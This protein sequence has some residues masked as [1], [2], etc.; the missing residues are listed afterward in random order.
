MK[1]LF[2][3][4]GLALILGGGFYVYN[5]YSFAPSISAPSQTPP[6][7]YKNEKYGFAITF[8]AT[9]RGYSVR[10]RTIG[11]GV[12]YVEFSLP[13][14][15]RRTGLLPVVL[16]QEEIPMFGIAAYSKNQWKNNPTPA[17]TNVVVL[18]KSNDKYLSYGVDT[19]ALKTSEQ[20]KDI[21]KLLD[22]SF[23]LPSTEGGTSIYS[24]SN[25]GFSV[26]YPTVFQAKVEY[27]DFDGIPNEFL[28]VGFGLGG[29]P[30]ITVLVEIGGDLPDLAEDFR[31]GMERVEAEEQTTLQGRQAI[32][33][34]GWT[35]LF[36]G[37]AV[38]QKVTM[39]AFAAGKN[40]YALINTH[41]ASAAEELLSRMANSIR[42]P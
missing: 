41:P 5:N 16:A 22:S 10:E 2:I 30:T 13:T 33:M 20:I 35:K 26:Q 9:W 12:P 6:L 18:K 32:R 36:P 7:S 4:L 34:T 31:S 25:F 17:G 27:E 3:V 39:I 15:Q 14:K 42:I 40:T 38:A 37:D 19:Q 11:V 24:S 21:P 23:P 8:P 29:T 1:L 28:R